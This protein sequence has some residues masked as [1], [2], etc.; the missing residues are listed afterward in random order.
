MAVGYTLDE[1]KNDITQRTVAAFEPS[2]DYVVVKIPRWAFEKFP[3]VDRELGPQ[4]KSVGE[5]MAIGR[6]FKEALQKGVRSWKLA[7]M[8]LDRW[9]A[10]PRGNSRAMSPMQSC[11]IC[12][13]FPTVTASLPPT[14]IVAWRQCC[15]HL[16]NHAL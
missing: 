4:M 1:L 6:T 9:S 8:A 12:C 16:P 15:H 10:M 2:I 11:M 5:V 3:G 13:A 14:G 7:A